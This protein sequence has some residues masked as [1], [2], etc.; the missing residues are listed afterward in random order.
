M[1]PMLLVAILSGFLM[2]SYSQQPWCFSKNCAETPATTFRLDRSNQ[3]MNSTFFTLPTLPAYKPVAPLVFSPSARRFFQSSA[4]MDV[5]ALLR[6]TDN[7][8][9]MAQTNPGSTIGRHATAGQGS[10]H[11]T[12]PTLST[13]QG[14]MVFGST[15][16]KF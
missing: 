11:V 4:P 2:P 6:A 16:P 8:A 14:A 9:A 7:A 1:K 10:S 13:G 5:G 15:S 3:P 12:G